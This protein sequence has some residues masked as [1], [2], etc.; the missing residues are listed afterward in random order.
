MAVDA[1]DSRDLDV[2]GFRLWW[3]KGPPR[4]S[5]E[6]RSRVGK[7]AATMLMVLGLASIVVVALKGS[8]SQNRPTVAPAVNGTATG[9]FSSVATTTASD[10]LAPFSKESLPSAPADKK[11]L[12][13]PTTQA[14]LGSSA[15]VM[16]VPQETVLST[17]SGAKPNADMLSLGTQTELPSGQSSD[18]KPARTVTLRPDGAPIA[19]PVTVESSPADAPKPHA[20]FRPL[21]MK[22]APEME[23][24]VNSDRTTKYPPR[25]PRSRVVAQREEAG[26]A[27][28]PDP[29]KQP[30]LAARAGKPDGAAI[31]PKLPQTATDPPRPETPGEA[32]RQSFNRMVDTLF[33]QRDPRAAQ[34]NSV[35]ASS[36]WA[37]Q[38]AAPGSETEAESDRRR[39]NVQHAATLKGSNI[40]VQKAVV[41]GVTVYRLRVVDLSKADASALCARLK[42]EGGSC[43]VAR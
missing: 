40:G 7:L 31:D 9:E 26:E 15:E 23:R 43:F 5:I 24:P 6:R 41:D 11:H 21:A 2:Q 18:V 4:K 25:R 27:A 38:L 29:S 3:E 13:E 10:N 17:A 22:D 20:L 28:A 12:A 33:G 32:A 34:T 1:D 37:V 19:A 39:I 14:S 16:A 36:G 8:G 30:V 35:S 42:V